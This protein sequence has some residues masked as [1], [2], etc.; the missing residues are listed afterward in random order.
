MRHLAG[1]MGD[2]AAEQRLFAVGFDQDAHMPGAVA[3][4]GI[5]LISSQSR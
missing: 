4:V 5:T 3:G 1:V 2:V